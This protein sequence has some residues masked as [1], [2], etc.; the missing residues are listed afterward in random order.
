MIN[1]TVLQGRLVRDPELRTTQSGVEIVSLTIAW[2][3][4]YKDVESKLF[5]KCTAWRQTGVFINTYFKKGQEICVEGKLETRSYQ[6]K[7][8]NNRSVTELIVDKAHFCGK[9]SDGQDST[10]QQSQQSFNVDGLGS[11]EDIDAN[12][13]DLPF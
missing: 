10:P 5:L 1:K 6:D 4:K 9:K 11:F 8:G 12:P 7:D 13:S 3:E 2:S